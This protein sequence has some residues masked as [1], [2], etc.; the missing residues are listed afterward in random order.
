L[1]PIAT[2]YGKGQLNG[3]V[4]SGVYLRQNIIS[5]NSVTI[6]YESLNTLF[7]ITGINPEFFSPVT[8]TTAWGSDMS[9]IGIHG[10]CFAI[11][12]RI[13]LLAS[14]ANM[15]GVYFT[16][17]VPL[18]S[19]IDDDG[20][21]LKLSYSEMIKMGTSHKMT[22]EIVLNEYIRNPNSLVEVHR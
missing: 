16:G 17:H 11:E 5:G 15:S 8:M 20:N 4:S 18:G 3:N 6:D 7:P 2:A 9:D 10:N 1:C 19:L 21:L 13:Q 22:S 12:A 14:S